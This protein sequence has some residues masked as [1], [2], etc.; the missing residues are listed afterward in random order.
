MIGNEYHADIL[1]ADNYG[2]DS[3]YVFTAQSGR[4]PDSLPESC[5]RIETIGDVF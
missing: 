4:E 1:G 2:I 3:M 5:R